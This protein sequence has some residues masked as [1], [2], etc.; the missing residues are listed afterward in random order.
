MKPEE[1]AR[2]VIDSIEPLRDSIYG[3]RYRVAAHLSDGTYLPCVVLQSRQALVRLAL[4]RFK[5]EHSHYESIV[6]TFVAGGTCVDDYYLKDVEVSPFAWPLER[7]KEIHGETVMGWTAFVAEM[8]DGTM[9]SYG[10]SFSFDF[11][12]LPVGYSHSDI[13]KIHSGMVYSKDSGLKAFSM[14][15]AQQTKPFRERP[16]FTC[17]LQDLD[18][19]GLATS[20]DA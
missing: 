11:F 15:S 14:N 7:L 16:F 13:V 17:Y 18:A 20:V 3:N 19:A 5:E 2:F 4:R 12:E 9:H 8:K 10:T 6:G 1:M